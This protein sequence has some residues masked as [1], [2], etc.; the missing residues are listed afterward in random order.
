MS[1]CAEAA[2]G[3]LRQIAEIVYP[4]ARKAQI[5]YLRGRAVRY[6]ELGKTRGDRSALLIAV[7]IFDW[8]AKDSE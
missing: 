4:S 5:T 7:E 3:K 1:E 8:L 2:V 6:R